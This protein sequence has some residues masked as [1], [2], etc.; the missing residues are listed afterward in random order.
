[1]DDGEGG[2]FVEVVGFTV[3]YTLNSRL[4]TSNIQSG[5]TYRFQY[6]A[7]NIHGWSEFSPI[8]EILSATTPSIPQGEPETYIDPAET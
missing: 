3:A 8:G 6:R 4:I 2:T 1:M 5:K 7:Q